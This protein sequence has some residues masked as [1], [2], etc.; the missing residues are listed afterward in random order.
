ML[1]RV[2]LKLIAGLLYLFKFLLLLLLVLSILAV[3]DLFFFFSFNT[4]PFSHSSTAQVTSMRSI[5]PPT[6]QPW[7]SA[8][9]TLRQTSETTSA[10]AATT[11]AVPATRSTCAFAAAWPP[12]GP[13]L[14]LWPR[15]SCWWPS[16]SSTRRGESPMRSMTVRSSQQ[17]HHLT[18]TPRLTGWCGLLLRGLPADYFPSWYCWRFSIIWTT[19]QTI[20]II[21]SS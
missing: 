9:W 13:S 16:S 20:P 4:I 6:R 15:W 14:A 8:T 10:S 19:T 12:S 7:P 17:P 3:F 2:C 1:H 11:W 18:L 5:A 21:F